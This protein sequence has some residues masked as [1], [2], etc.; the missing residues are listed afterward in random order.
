MKV[1]VVGSF[2]YDLMVDA[3][4]PPA[5]GETLR[6]TAFR[7][8]VGGKG[9]N[10]AVAAARAG[11]EVSFVGMLGD[12]P[13]GAEFREAMGREGI[14]DRHVTNSDVPNSGTGVGMPVVYPDGSNSIII[15]PRANSEVTPAHIDAARE[16]IASADAV[17]MQLEI[18]N[19]AVLRAAELAH[20]LG[21]RVVL[22]PAPFR[23]VPARI[24]SSIDLF[25]PNEGE[26]QSFCD[27]MGLGHDDDIEAL[28]VRFAERVG[29]DTLVT[30]GDRGA[31][32]A[33]RSGERVQVSGHRVKA[34]DSVGAGDAFC[35]AL[36]ARLGESGVTREVLDFANAAAA[37]SVT[38]PGSGTSAPTEAEIESMLA[39]SGR[40]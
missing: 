39:T 35:G 27:A 9:F 30:L 25:V 29:V 2:M 40:K 15:I 31:F 10:Q 34:V 22:N 1:A 23:E 20:E 7:R 11:A 24:W 36:C 28:A 32:L 33:T 14:D 21:V 8:S 4:R 6:G 3:P 17:L 37:L 13:F 38:R 26:L 18:P 12:D 5:L 16:A 19:D